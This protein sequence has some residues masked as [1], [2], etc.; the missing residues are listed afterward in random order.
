MVSTERFQLGLHAVQAVGGIATAMGR[1]RDTHALELAT[2]IPLDIES[3]S[4]ILDALDA[5]GV[6]EITSHEGEFKRF[7]VVK[8]DYESVSQLVRSGDHLRNPGLVR[9]LMALRSDPEWVRK[10]RDQHSIIRAITSL[11]PKTNLE[12]L[13]GACG[14]SGARV[15]A[16]L[17]D[18]ETEG[19]AVT[20]YLE[21]EDTLKVELPPTTYPKDRFARNMEMLTAEIEKKPEVQP[22]WRILAGIAGILVILFIASRFM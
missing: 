14:V 6:V 1:N 20:V 10:T 7:T 4:R 9:N 21:D 11:G 22:I 16:V 18:F 12:N 8:D 19:Y 2:H 15:R 17:G 3:I 13:V 5:E